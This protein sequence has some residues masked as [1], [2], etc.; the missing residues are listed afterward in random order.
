MIDINEAAAS[1]LDTN[2]VVF[3]P[4]EIRS[5]IYILQPKDPEKHKINK[6]KA[7]QLG[8]LEIKWYNYF[9]DPGL[10]KVG[11]FKYGLDNQSKF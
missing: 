10:L 1:N 11:P 8:Q 5:F 7:E 4:D 2:C 6:F 9:G 3:N